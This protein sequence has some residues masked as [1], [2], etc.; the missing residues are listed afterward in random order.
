[1]KEYRYETHIHSSPCSKCGWE[2]IETM[3]DASI[4]A[5]YAGFI[6]TNHF[7]IGNSGIDRELPWEEF[8][9]AYAEDYERGRKY[10]QARDFD[11]LFGLECGYG[12]GKEALIYGLS[13]EVVATLP[14]FKTADL[15]TLSAMVHA[16]GGLVFHAHPFRNRPYI[17]DPDKEPD[18]TLI[19]GVETYNAENPDDRNAIAEAYAEKYHLPPLSGGDVHKREKVGHAGIITTK[20]LRTN[21]DL[22][23]V[24]KSGDYQLILPE[25]EPEK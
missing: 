22:L 12:G 24:L 7:Y 21:A 17:E 15:S 23:E 13:P 10:A 11:V 6:I 3:V 8:V 2:S 25:K 19:D 4:E 20:R 9:G 16:H 5:G 18:P 1:M 14:A